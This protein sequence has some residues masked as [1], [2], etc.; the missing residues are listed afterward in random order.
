MREEL[1]AE[2]GAEDFDA[3]VVCV[4]FYCK[5]NPYSILIFGRGEGLPLTKERSSWIQGTSSY[6]DEARYQIFS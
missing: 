2:A 1:V 6:A 5:I 4:C 3:W